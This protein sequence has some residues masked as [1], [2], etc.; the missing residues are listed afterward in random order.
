[1]RIIKTARQHRPYQKKQA[2]STLFSQNGYCLFVLI[3]LFQFF[4]FFFFIQGGTLVWALRFETSPQAIDDADEDTVFS[5]NGDSVQ[6]NLLISFVTDGDFGDFRITIDTHGPSGV[7]TPDGRFDLEDDWVITGEVGAGVNPSDGPRAIREA[8]DGNDFSRQQGEKNPHPLKDGRYRIKIEI[9]AIPND[10]VNTAESEYVAIELS[11]V[12]DKTP[13]QLSAAVSQRDLSPNGDSIRDATQIRY[14]LSEDL[15]ALQ[16]EFI[17]P[18]DRP[19]VS[20]GNHSFTWT[21]SDGLGTLLSDGTYTL[22][23]RGTDKGGNVGTFGIGSIRID[24]EAPI[25][26]QVT[27]S[28]NAFWNTSVEQIEAIFSVGEGSPIDFSPTFTKITLENENGIISGILSHNESTNRVTL[29]LDQPLDTSDENGVYTVSVSGGDKAGNIVQS[30]VQFTFDTVAPTITKLAADGGEL[31]PGASTGVQLTFV[32]AILEDNIDAGLNFGVSTIRLSGPREAVTGVQRHVGENGIRWTLGF[33]LAAD[34]SDDGVY[35]ITVQPLDRAGND[36]GESQIPFIYDT[37][38]P[39]LISLTSETGVQLNASAGAKTFLSSSLSLITA[40]F[41]DGNGGGVDFG[42][43]TIEMVPIVPENGAEV[44]VEG[45]TTSDEDNNMLEF[46]LTQPLE[47]R[48]GSQDG[49][50]RIRVTSTDKAG[51]SQTEN[52]DLTYDTQ[53][54]AIIST[55]PAGNETVSSLT[56]VSVILNTSNGIDFSATTVKLLRADG[57]AVNTDVR[58]NGKD[59]ISLTLAEPLAINGSDDGEY[60]IEITP[61]DGAGNA[62]STVRPRFFVAS[63]MPEIRLNTPTETRINTLTTIEAQL[64]D[65]I[66]VGLD[67]S[68]SKSTIAVRRNGTIVAAKSV[69]AEEPGARLIW[70]IDKPLSRDGSADGEYTVSVQYTDLVDRSFTADFVLTL[71]TQVPAITSTTPA[72]GARVS[73]LDS[74]TVTLTDNLSGVDLVETVVSLMAPGNA[75]VPGT[76]RSGGNQITLSFTPLKTDGRADGVYRIE[77]TPI[78][79]AGNVGSLSVIEFTYA[80]QA[81]DIDTLTP[82]DNAIVNRVQEIRALLIDNSGEGVDFDQSTITLKSASGDEILGALRND[83]DLTLILEAALPTNGA[84][85]GGYTVELHL[86][87]KLGTAADY[88]RRFTYDSQLPIITLESRLPAENPIVSNLLTHIEATLNDTGTGIDFDH[89][90]II[91]KAPDQSLITGRQRVEEAQS[92]ITWELNQ[93]LPRDGSADGEYTIQ[94]SIF[95]KAGNNAD[96]EQ[97]FVYDT[98]IPAIVAVTANT[99]P[100]TPIPAEGLAVINQSFARLAVKL[101]DTNGGTTQMS[102][103]DLVGTDIRLLAPGNAPVGINIRDDGV[104]I[105]TVSFASLRQRGTYIV[106][107]T[108]QD[109]AGNVSG[110]AIEYK[111]NLELGRS[112]VSDVTIDD[113]SAPVAF[114]NRLDEIVATLVDVSGTGLDLTTDGS[115]TTVIGPNGEVDGDQASRGENQIVWTPLQLATDGSADGVYTV[116]VTPVDSVGRSGTP[117]RHQFTLDTQG[118]EVAAVTP[119]DFTQPI[120]YIGQQLTQITAQVIDVGPAGLEI[121]SQGLQLRNAQGDVVVAD[122]TDDGNTQIFLTLSQPLATD[123]SDDGVYTVVLDLIDK[124]RN[125]DTRSHKLVY[126]TQAPTLVSTDPADG[127]LRSDD[128]TLITV[129]L[130]DRGDS[131][132]DFVASQLTLLDPSGNLISGK[133]NNDGHGKLTLQINGLAEDGNYTIRVQAVDRAG[134]G[135]NAPFEANFTFSSGMPV[136]VS[137]LPKTTPAEEAFTN[138]PLRQVEVELQSDDG[139]SNRSTITLLSPE[140]T[141]VS[142]QQ[143]RQGNKLIYRLLRELAADGSDDGIYTVSVTPVNSAGRRGTPEQFTF[144]YDTVPPEVDVETIRLIVAEPGVNNALNEIQVTITDDEPSSAIDWDNLDDSWLTLEAPPVTESSKSEPRRQIGGTL[145]SDEQQLLTFRLT[146]SL[147]NDGSQDGTY[148]VTIAPKDRAGN[149]TETVTYEFSY[150]TRPPTIDTGSLFID[151]QPLLVDSND[152]D[153]PSATNGGGGVIIDATLSDINPDGSRGLGVDLAQSSITVRSSEGNV[154][155]GATTQNGSNRIR[156]KSGPL[157]EQGLYQVTITGVGLDDANLGFQP[158]DSISTQF[159]FETTKPV[160]ELTDFGGETI[161]EDE[162]APLQGTAHDPSASESGIPASEVAL[163]EIVGTGPD[164]EPINPVV[165]EDN[166]EEEEEPWSR[167]SLDFLP[168]QSGEYNL[169]IRVTDRAG[170]VGVYDAV[171]ANFSVSLIFK[172]PTYVWPNPLSFLRRSNG[173]IARF[174]FEVNVPGGEGAKITLSIYDFA[175]DLVYEKEF[176]DVIPGRNDNEVTWDL[177]NQS[178]TDV[179]RGVYIFRL[180]AEDTVTNNHTNAVGKILV[181]E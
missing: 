86:V 77:V 171:T 56:Q 170:N 114:V 101:S 150:D 47:M 122:Q 179:A 97:A 15:A 134:N 74:V 162:S 24:T 166:S 19:A 169:D 136:V 49:P 163:V 154:I 159:L 17:N 64:F 98:L 124:A 43:T 181:V 130:N 42:A 65:Y 95:D 4:P 173:E 158:T 177:K 164:D 139:G 168:A 23:L 78:D 52:F 29:T 44:P 61:L 8:W 141:T 180:E 63:R 131:G 153:Y 113:Q 106:E 62:G 67:F 89:S 135:A 108:P 59:T 120:S 25:I 109:L 2:S 88:T 85:D 100:P 26:S 96:M 60:I 115:T 41:N 37:Q 31:T 125:L 27:P 36:A 138:E 155:S 110:Y 81:P 68:A 148:R 174:S 84:A 151:E 66:G 54:P 137:T 14:G 142:G 165:A 34:G 3:L 32:E 172:G 167:W 156:F 76:K 105:I 18:S 9:D 55:N 71:D 152:P 46:R 140:G 123:G 57:G 38:A 121:E 92:S 117:S 70:S 6:D 126:D 91:L 73:A 40:T 119:I 103:I 87:N 58:N 10:S 161:L 20:L 11:A 33:L 99:D 145:S 127:A 16:L 178:G 13:P 129:N 133:Q 116:T 157:S 21:G 107:I 143:V 93:L 160:A 112:S 75:T 79:L 146:I 45:T 128:I 51:N 35:T 80:T 118:P 82:P 102:G 48:D 50:Y 144:V 12:I 28:Q 147:A 30:E 90:T 39:K 5:P 104:D 72:E 22:Q 111:F 149:V 69:A 7:G 1:M 176:R 53:V 94:L 175:G 83:K 132:I